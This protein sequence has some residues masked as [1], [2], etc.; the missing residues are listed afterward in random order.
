[1]NGQAIVEIADT[2]VG[3]AS[4]DIPHI[5][6]KFYRAKNVLSGFEG[7]GLGLSIVKSVIERHNGRIWVNSQMGKGTVFS[8]ILPLLIN[9]GENKSTPTKNTKMWTKKR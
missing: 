2:G 9:T 3:I 8:I 4:E 5:F 7:T 6:D 1:M